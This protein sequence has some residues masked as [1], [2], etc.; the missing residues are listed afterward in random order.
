[1]V[2]TMGKVEKKIA[3]M[4]E[5]IAD[6]ELDMLTNLKQKTSSTAEISIGEYQRRIETMKKELALLEGK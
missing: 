6:M 5:R 4:K 1:M 3:K 2:S